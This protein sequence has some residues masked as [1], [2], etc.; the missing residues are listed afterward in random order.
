[1]RSPASKPS[2]SPSD[3]RCPAGLRR[4]HRRQPRR[5]SP[6][7]LETPETATRNHQRDVGLTAASELETSHATIRREIQWGEFPPRTT[8]RG[9]ARIWWRKAVEIREP[10]II[11]PDPLPVRKGTAVP[12]PEGLTS[13]MTFTILPTPGGP[14]RRPTGETA[15]PE[16]R[17]ERAIL[18]SVAHVALFRSPDAGGPAGHREP[19]RQ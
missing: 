19:M 10:R 8:E 18:T 15:P 2:I 4:R 14:L 16:P 13:T 1:M 12:L 9:V 5:V 7:D 17:S 3:I 11:R 6:I